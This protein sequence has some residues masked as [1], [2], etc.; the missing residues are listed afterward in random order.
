MDSSRTVRVLALCCL[1]CALAARATTAA[2]SGDKHTLAARHQV[3][4][5]SRVELALQVGG[6]VK[7]VG[8]KGQAHNLPMSVLANLGYDEALV[9]LDDAGRAV[10]SVRY[11]DDT[12][13][14]IK[15]DKGGEKPL[16]DP[17][18]RLIIAE[19]RDQSP[20]LL[21]CASGRLS[22]EELDLLDLPGGTLVL[23][24][25]LPAKEVAL[26]ESWKLADATLAA[27]LCL[28]A[29]AWSDVECVLGEVKDQVADVAAAGNVSGAIG[30]ISTDVELKIKY[31]FDVAQGRITNFAM[32]I[33]EKRAIG[34]IG[35]GLDTVAK[36]LVKITPISRSRT[37]SADVLNGLPKGSNADLLALDY[38]PKNGLFR[39]D[40][41]RRW[42]VTSDDAK[43]AVLRLLDRGELVAQCNVSALPAVKKPVTLTE[44]Q[45]DIE[46]TL[47]KNFGQFVS[48]AQT[49]SEAGYAVFRVVVHGTV[50]QLPIEWV[51]YLIQD[52]Q[53]RRVSLAFTFQES[54][55]ERFAAADRG[56]VEALR[57]TD[58]PAP[59][60]AKPA[61]AR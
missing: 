36:V 54:L 42:Y 39:F 61:T 48:A 13:A 11:Y 25:L 40:Y 5:L 58:P 32:L 17:A 56:V 2:Q 34:H 16:V 47:D 28:D 53:G 8:E 18:H 49:T 4:E 3:G 20:A 15:I 52:R 33:K 19:R 14:V 9:A 6:E 45:G 31:K 50:G 60:A 23:D 30:G 26:G 44:F 41:D 7:L 37:L 1:G 38:T 35:P 55:R 21:Y 51:Y 12:R 59:T 24:A 43:L 46:R 29:V 57:L 10:R 22:R 27:L